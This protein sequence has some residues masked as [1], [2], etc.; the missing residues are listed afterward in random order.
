MTTLILLPTASDA[1]SEYRPSKNA[2]VDIL[3]S[4]LGKRRDSTVHQE[5]DG[6]RIVKLSL[7]C[8]YI[9]L[10]SFVL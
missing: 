6:A 1:F 10:A 4:P 9:V 2:H 7:R 3:S 8:Q 5:K